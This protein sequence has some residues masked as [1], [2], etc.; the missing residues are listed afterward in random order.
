MPTRFIPK[1]ILDLIKPQQVCDYAIA[2]GWQ[3]V[4]NVNG[5][6]SLFNHPKGQY[7]Q[8]IVPMDDSMD[9][10]SRRI[11]DLVEILADF[12]SRPVLQILNDMCG[13][14]FLEKIVAF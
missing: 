8:L 10:Y 14:D 3:I 1:E 4:P 7:D 5:C 13:K 11:R 9:D 2:N 6:I 12:E